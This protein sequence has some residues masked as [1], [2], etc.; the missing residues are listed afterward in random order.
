[1]DPL[2]EELQTAT[3]RC[4]EEEEKAW[5]CSLP[6]VSRAF[7]H[8]SFDDLHLY[9]GGRGKLSLEYQ[10]PGSFS[11]ADMVLLGR[12]RDRPSAVFVELKNWETRNDRPGKFAGLMERHTGSTLHPSDQ[13]RGYVDY[14]REFHSSVADSQAAVHGCVLFTADRWCHSYR[15]HP[16]DQLTDQYPVFTLADEDALETLPA[17]FAE[18]LTEPDEKFAMGFERGVYRQNRNFCRQIAQQILQPD[19]TQFVLLDNQ[20]YAF[21]KCWE[22]IQAAIFNA[23]T[24]RHMTIVIDGPPGSGKSVIAARLWASLVQDKRMPDGN[25]ALVTT[26]ASQNSNW[27]YIFN[28]VANNRAAQGAVLKA[29]NFYPS[30]A[31]A[32]SAL[33]NR[34]DVAPLPAPEWRKNLAF[35]KNASAG[36]RMPDKHILVSIVDEAHALINPETSDGRGQFGFDPRLGPQAWHIIRGSVVSIFLLDSQQSFRDRENTTVADLKFWTIEQ[37]AEIPEN[38][39]LHGNQFRCQGSKDYVDWIEATLRGQPMAEILQKAQRWH[40]GPVTLAFHDGGQLAAE[41]GNP[42]GNGKQRPRFNFKV[43][44]DPNDM[45]L[46]IRERLNDGASARLAATYSVPWPT[47]KAPHP[48]DL[49]A[50]SHD[51]YLKT[52]N[53]Y[54]SRIWNYVP[55]NGDYTHFV[56]AA[57]AGRIAVDPLAEVGCPYAIRG[58]DFDY[59]GILWLHDLVWRTDRWVINLN[60]VHETGLNRALGRARREVG[61]D[62]PHHRFLLEKIQQAYRILFTRAIKGVA[63]YVADDETR[64]FLNDC[65]SVNREGR[66][67]LFE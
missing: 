58:F 60:H 31:A 40:R 48:H 7:R 49:P 56:Q 38:I 22:L 13:V 55:Q 26:S 17:Y 67:V 10:L 65:L 3:G 27:S 39:S 43:F 1:M 36:T 14:C 50:Q 18:R 53:G 20:R 34:H 28:Q 35:L 42:Y 6:A 15:E 61:G 16:N 46:A 2:V 62:G 57:P 21:S 5:R 44:D 11:W 45:E 30:P 59:L 4:G 51:F 9:F 52:A 8:R 33:A 47:Q 25:V 12:H 24:P 29:N 19:S 41:V 66:T 37:G 63:V 32:F 64:A 23:E 54:W